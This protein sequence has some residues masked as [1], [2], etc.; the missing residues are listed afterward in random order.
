MTQEMYLRDCVA[1]RYK[2][3]LDWLNAVRINK[4]INQSITASLYKFHYLRFTIWVSLCELD[5]LTLTIWAS[6]FEPRYLSLLIWA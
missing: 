4:S 5:Y 2:I 3:T 6:L 1:P